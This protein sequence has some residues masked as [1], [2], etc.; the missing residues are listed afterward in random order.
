M[1]LPHPKGTLALATAIAVA[2]LGACSAQ[3]DST[4]GQN[5]QV[6]TVTVDPTT[7]DLAT[8]QATQF[9]ATVT[10]SAN[11]AVTWQVD[12]AGGGAVTEAGLYTAPAT[13]GT[14][15]VRAVS[16]QAPSASATATVTVTAPP[17]G[18][19]VISPKTLRVIA[20]GTATFTATVTGLSSSDVSWSVQEAS[21]CG[22]VSAGGVYTAPG[23]AA[24]CHVVATSAADPGKS[25]VATVTVAAPV[26]VAVSPRTASVAAG[27]T[28]TFT[29]AV[30][31]GVL[32]SGATWS[33]QEASG[34]GS[35][36]SAGVYH[37]PGAAGTCHVVATSK[38]DASKSDTATIT[39][40]AP[41]AVA[42][43]PRTTSVAAGGTVAFSATVT[44]GVLASG[45]TWKVQES[46]G[47]GSV[48]AA[49]AYT[50]PGA[51]ATCHVVA[52]SKEDTSKSDTATITV[53]VTPS[54]G[55]AIS[56]RTASVSAGGTVTFTATVTGLSG[57]GVTW[58][59]QESSG[60][61]SVSAG[62]VYTAPGA[63]ATCHVVVTS[64]ADTTKSD[65]ATI[66]VTGPVAV[67][68][69]PTTATVDAC[70][71]STFTAS[72]SGTS[73][74]AVT[75]SVAEGATGGSVSTGGVYT[76]PSTAGTYHVIA[77]SH[78]SASA[79][80]RA[81]VTVND[82]VLSV[83]VA[84]VSVSVATGTAQQFTA[85]VT[86]SCGTFA[87]TGP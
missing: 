12:E 27:G 30:T 20:G 49:G 68:L 24:T 48:N 29:A 76:A 11:T 42:V 87:A 28:V 84:P 57:N 46:S 85:T 59:V 43:S 22:S 17:A 60:C 39:V 34:C 44:G 9:A 14:F 23:A 51:A 86:T 2:G 10:G 62:G 81:T 72:V 38:E 71:T 4:G 64:T 32:G 15:H 80:A 82:H 5:A 65:T 75:W 26:A 50:A 8:S 36:T 35:I 3:V 21:S 70:K 79:T 47:C 83:A 52:T 53:T 73:D 67:T 56:P 40:A 61:G 78:A 31:G 1:H 58:K 18:S 25:D 77:T 45:V 19:V 13:A 41:V 7:A 63:A 6:V 69:S 74:Q 66:T 54:S 16:Q 33:V 55:V 37:A